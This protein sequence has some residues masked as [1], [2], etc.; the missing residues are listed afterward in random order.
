MNC[1]RCGTPG[2]TGVCNSC[3]FPITK[4]WFKSKLWGRR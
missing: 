3:G 4:I 2:F 1:P